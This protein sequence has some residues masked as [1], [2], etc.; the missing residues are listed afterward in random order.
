MI[1]TNKLGR[2]GGPQAC[3][4]DR[5]SVWMIARGRSKLLTVAIAIGIITGVLTGVVSA[6]LFWWWQAK[7][8]RPKLLLCLTIA[9]YKFARDKVDRYQIKI[10]NG[11]RRLAVDLRVTVSM[12]VPGLVNPDSVETVLFHKFEN[13]S[14]NKNI[15]YRIQPGYMPQ[16]VQRR[17]LNYLPAHLSAAIRSGKPVDLGE[18][19]KLHEDAF[20]KVSA[21]ATDSFS[22]ASGFVQGKYYAD[23]VRMG[24]FAG[25]KSCEHSGVF[26]EKGHGDENAHSH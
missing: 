12:Y 2:A 4:V 20:L 6:T 8:M 24:K 21:S 25:G 13:P 15:R 18:F 22:G 17:Y 23:S 5:Q 16:D 3:M 11:R 10:I 19:F 7:L 26:E 14:L 1:D 9:H